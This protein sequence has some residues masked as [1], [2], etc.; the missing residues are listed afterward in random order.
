MYVVNA[1]GLSK[2]CS[3]LHLI[4]LCSLQTSLPRI[5][6]RRHLIVHVCLLGRFMRQCRVSQTC[7]KKGNTTSHTGER[8][9]NTDWLTH[10]RIPYFWVTQWGEQG[11]GDIPMFATNTL[12]REGNKK[13]SHPKKILRPPFYLPNFRSFLIDFP[14][15]FPGADEEEDGKNG[16]RM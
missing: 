5:I 7:T 2:V 12:E 8:R 11:G 15:S 14:V 16:K 1:A 3:C 10:Q 9:K 6:T 13:T 4:Q